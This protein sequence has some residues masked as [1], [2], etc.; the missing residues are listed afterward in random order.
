MTTLTLK[1]VSHYSLLND[2]EWLKKKYV[3][4]RLSTSKIAAEVGCKEAATV[5]R[6]LKKFGISIRSL[7]ERRRNEHDDHFHLNLPV[8][9]GSLLGDAFITK[10]QGDNW[11]CSFSKRNIH[12]DHLL[13]FAKQIF[14]DH[15][16]CRISGPFKSATNLTIN[17]EPTYFLNTYK[18]PEITALREIWY[19]NGIKI[20]PRDLTLTKESLLHWFL[21]DG[22]S[23]IVRKKYKNSVYT[24]VRI[25]FCTQSFTRQDLEWLSK[26]LQVQFGI[27]FHLASKKNKRGKIQYLLRVSESQVNDFLDLIG[28]CP[29]DSLKY[30]WKR[31]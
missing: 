2:K 17:G 21:D 16:E 22:Y 29:I 24:S 28:E 12:Y 11:H 13:F 20:I 30:K 23:Y 7:S 8:I 19:P 6:N 3:D 14:T 25:L 9:N 15:A 5:C 31:D 4:E 18:H 1:D 10:K 26:K 27:V